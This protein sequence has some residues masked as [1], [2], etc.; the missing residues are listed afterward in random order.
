MLRRMR[1]D[2]AISLAAPSE[3]D[4][5]L[6]LLLQQFEGHGIDTPPAKLAEA[7]RAVLAD[8][9]LGFFL[10]ARADGLVGVAYV[11][12]TWALEHC[13][14]TAWLEEL[15]VV[16]EWRD[17]GLGQDLLAEAMRHA[18]ALGAAAVDLEVDHEHARAEN[19]YRRN[20]FHPLP[21][22]RWVRRLGI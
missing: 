3:C 12:F 17:R 15:Y 20:G 21:R 7:V 11:S 1:A 10:V 9:R 6:D 18:A 16:P 14:K 5:V 19:L 22:A 13:G 2:A 4:A 8:E